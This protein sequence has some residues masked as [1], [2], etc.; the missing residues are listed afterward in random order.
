MESGMNT[1]IG[2][3]RTKGQEWMTRRVE[4]ASAAPVTRHA[5]ARPQVVVIGCG[6]AGLAAAQALANRP[7]HVTIVDRANHHLFQPLLYQV[8]TAG[9]AAPAIAAPIRHVLRAARNVTTLLGEVASIDVAKQ[10]IRLDRGDTLGYDYLI[11]ASGATHSYFGRD[12]WAPFA[13]G[14]KTLDD[15]LEI[16]RRILLAFERAEREPDP[17]Q[18]R[19]WLTFAVVGAGPT[20]VELAGTLAEIARYTLRDEFRHIDSKDARIVLL[21]G[22]DRVLP[23]YPADLSQKARRQL[24]RLRVDVRTGCRVTEIDAEGLSMGATRLPARTVLWAAGVSA[25]SLGGDLRAGRDRA[26]RIVVQPDLSIA[27]HSNVFVAGDLA[28]VTSGGKPVPGIAQAAKQ[29]GRRAARNVLRRIGGRPT[30]AFKYYDYGSLATIGRSAAVAAIGRFKFSG[31]P[32]WLLWLCVHIYSLIGFR[33]RLVVLID[34]AWAY[35]TSRR[36]ARVMLDRP[37]K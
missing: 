30:V 24:E 27:E 35:W 19:A 10:Q 4:D 7:V 28:D 36:Y 26:G 22:T 8:A 2:F 16:R 20:G 21:E 15:A 25:S 3:Q 34:W 31:R 32:A 29:M 5:A 33:N 14:L 18:R 6:F 13:P 37:G 17:Q 9:L 12:D 11:V 1:S 23:T